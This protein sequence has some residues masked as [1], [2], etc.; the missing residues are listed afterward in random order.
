MNDTE[1]SS[2][3]ETGLS[4]WL[5][6]TAHP[7]L[8]GQKGVSF[9]DLG[10]YGVCKETNVQRTFLTY[11]F[12]LWR[13]VRNGRGDRRRDAPI[14]HQLEGLVDAG[15]MCLVLGR[16]GSGCSTFLKTIAGY[17]EGL[18]LEKNSRIYH[19]CKQMPSL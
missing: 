2:A 14:L 5:H 16:P 6:L 13:W 8:E 3:D 7:D 9:T 1:H 18:R 19:G 15:E 11:P 10:V 4:K 17:T 12:G